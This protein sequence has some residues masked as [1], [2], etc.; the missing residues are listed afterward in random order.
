MERVALPRP[1]L[2]GR[3][4]RAACVELA[5]SMFSGPVGTAYEIVPVWASAAEEEPFGEWFLAHAV[6]VG[7]D[8]FGLAE[9]SPVFQDAALPLSARVTGRLRRWSVGLVVAT[10]AYAPSVELALRRGAFGVLASTVVEVL[11]AEAAPGDEL[12]RPTMEVPPFCSWVR[13]RVG[14]LE[15][16]VQRA[17]FALSLTVD[18]EGN[19]VDTPSTSA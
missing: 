6:R 15:D 10:S 19:I 1:M 18:D 4:D 7:D 8:P 3:F 17:I 16:P 13:P 9:T 14:N 2:I 5:T 11:S 12:L